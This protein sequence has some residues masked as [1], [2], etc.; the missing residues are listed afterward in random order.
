MCKSGYR[1]T[2]LNVCVKEESDIDLDTINEIPNEAESV[3][4]WTLLLL[5]LIT[6][7]L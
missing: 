7:L 5:Q 6:L 4:I 1:M 3:G 2:A